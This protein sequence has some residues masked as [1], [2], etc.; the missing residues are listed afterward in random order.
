[1]TDD[2]TDERTIV[3]DS[4]AVAARVGASPQRA[5][6]VVIAGPNVGQMYPLPE[7]EATVGRGKEATIRIA[8]NEISR[9]HARFMRRGDSVIVADNDSTNGTFVN[10]HQVTF[11]A[12][13]NGDKI[14]VGTTTIL[15]F[16]L[17]DDLDARFQRQML[18]NAIRDG[19]T[20]AYNK[21]HFQE[22]LA[23]EV[24]FAREGSTA[25]SV[26]LFDLDHFKRI[27]DTYGHLA[28]DYVLATFSERVGTIIRRED[29]FARYG[30]EE[31]VVLSRGLDTGAG[32]AFADRIRTLVDDY[33]FA[34]EG[35]KIPV[36]VSAGVAAMP[37][38]T[39]E[40]ASELVGAAD[41]ALYAAK[42]NGRN[43]THAYGLR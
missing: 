26:I 14:Q 22:R 27:N 2:F 28:G 25:L 23:G 24:T 41:K 12:L 34:Y 33:D 3:G 35:Q 21:K 18:E 11:H 9:L 43:R 31:F 1:M 38:T 19:L 16:S 42:A 17:H 36:T 37:E 4:A 32:F 10:G 13:Q 8:D 15:R 6:V 30:G 29:V 39:V 5:T 40:V 7:S 20:G